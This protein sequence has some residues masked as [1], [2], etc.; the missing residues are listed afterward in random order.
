MNDLARIKLAAEAAAVDVEPA[1]TA[2]TAPA[3]SESDLA[4]RFVERHKHELRYVSGWGKWMRWDGSRW[5]TEE[6]LLAF[7]LSH[8]VCREA[9]REMALKSN[10]SPNGIASSKTAVGVEKLARAD[11]R[12]AATVDQW[13]SDIWLLNTPGGVV[14]LRTGEMRPGLPEDYMTKL[15]T[16]APDPE[17][18]IDL[19]LSVLGRSMDGDEQVVSYFSACSATALPAQR[20]RRHFT[21]STATV[22]TARPRS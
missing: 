13:N 8:R 6:T 2:D 19:W 5:Q 17:C 21:F 12:L 20:V 7:D 4:L 1:D 18:P 3:W 15:T 11:R 14:D 16:V 10:K 9:A 22:P